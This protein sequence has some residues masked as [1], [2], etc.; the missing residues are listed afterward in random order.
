MRAI[1]ALSLAAVLTA[2]AGPAL[3][4]SA[5]APAN[6]LR[7]G[8]SSPPPARTA[9]APDVAAE[10]GKKKDEAKPRRKRSEAQLANDNR[11]RACGQEWRANREKLK[12]QGQ[13]WLTF[14]KECRAR[15]KAQAR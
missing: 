15:L 3:A 14:S 8:G 1:L 10:A 11:M 12:T 5:A 6:P 9:P 2:V 13:T 7:P 4:Q